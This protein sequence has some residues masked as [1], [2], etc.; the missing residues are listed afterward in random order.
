MSERYSIVRFYLNGN[1]QVVKT[2]LTLQ[3]AQAHCQSPETSS[4][5]AAGKAAR[6]R[7]KRMG[8][9]FDGYQRERQSSD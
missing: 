2:G 6:A 8:A 9:W 1:K 5:T 4:R 7:T 3:E